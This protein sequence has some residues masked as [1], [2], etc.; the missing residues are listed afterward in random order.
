V[1]VG[2]WGWHRPW[3]AHHDQF[4]HDVEIHRYIDNRPGHYVRESA[5]YGPADVRVSSDAH[6]TTARE[7]E[8][9]R[10][11]HDVQKPAP[12]V[13]VHAPTHAA[14]PRVS[15]E[16][17]QSVAHAAA[18]VVRDRPGVANPQTPHV[19]AGLRTGERRATAVPQTARPAPAVANRA[20]A[21]EVSRPVKMPTQNVAPREHAAARNA[22]TPAAAPTVSPKAAPRTL[23]TALP[24]R[25]DVSAANPAARISH[26][27]NRSARD[28]D[29]TAPARPAERR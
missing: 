4:H 22:S 1:Y 9:K 11:E 14:V 13:D 25:S 15:A 23:G 27:S 3:W 21:R 28:A 24:P 8:A 12:R 16:S 10:W 26:E 17:T 29:R 6:R 18:P 2:N 20:P 7:V 5:R 19:Q